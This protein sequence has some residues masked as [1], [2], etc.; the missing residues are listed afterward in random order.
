MYGKERIILRNNSEVVFAGKNKGET[1]GSWM[2]LGWWEHT[3]NEHKARI[4][5]KEFR[6]RRPT[7]DYMF[8]PITAPT[9][10][11]LKLTLFKLIKEE[12]E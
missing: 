4:L 10:S 11:K 5:K 12:E 2:P 9:K 1:G 6:Y 8:M 7:D 3:K